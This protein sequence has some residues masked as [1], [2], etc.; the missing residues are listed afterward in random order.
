MSGVTMQMLAS[1]QSWLLAFFFPKAWR[2]ALWVMSIINPLA[3]GITW[4][5]CYLILEERIS[6]KGSQ[7]P[8]IA[9]VDELIRV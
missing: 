9:A 8:G 6:Y 5:P 3:L 4:K 1:N 7:L 2:A